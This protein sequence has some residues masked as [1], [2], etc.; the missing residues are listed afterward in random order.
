MKRRLALLTCLLLASVLA[1]KIRA[2]VT[3]AQEP[4]PTEHLLY[5]PNVVDLFSCSIVTEI[6]QSECEALVALWFATNP[7]F[8]D[9]NPS[10]RNRNGWLE[11]NTPCQWYG[12]SCADGHI[13]GIN[14]NDNGLIGT[15]PPE[16]SNLSNLSQLS[17]WDNQ[18]TSLP[19][20]IGNLSNLSY[21]DI[22]DNL[23]TSL[24]PEIGNLSNL[25]LLDL[26]RNQLTNLPAE[27]FNLSN[28][29]WLS[30]SINQLTSLPPEIGNL[31][32][33][34]SLQLGKNQLTSLPSTIRYLVNLQ[35]FGIEDNCL[36]ITDPDVVAFLDQK[37][38]GWRNQQRPTCD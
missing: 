37:S 1:L 29:S 27:I 9:S 14:I 8:P 31:S 32:N 5:L 4:P 34:H 28:L 12:I 18:L 21:L 30:L 38:A 26:S 22:S 16:I 20:E 10:W 24:P 17:F 19:A 6:P 23:L 3:H 36:V 11:T 13:S 33:L 25:R 15:I 35:N 2:D 7:F